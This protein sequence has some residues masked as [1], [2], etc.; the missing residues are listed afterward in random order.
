MDEG[1]VTIPL[2]LLG[3]EIRSGADD[4]LAM[5]GRHVEAIAGRSSDPD[6][7]QLADVVK[8]LIDLQRRMEQDRV[9]MLL[10]RR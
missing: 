2:T 4:H 3:G 10:R 1:M 7:A 9:N 6:V 8:N 5:L